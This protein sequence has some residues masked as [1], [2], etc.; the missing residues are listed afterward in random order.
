VQG[1]PPAHQVAETPLA[2]W[3]RQSRDGASG[4]GREESR[5]RRDGSR[6]RSL[7]RRRERSYDPRGA[8]CSTSRSRSASALRDWNTDELL[9]DRL[10]SLSRILV[11]LCRHDGAD[12]GL[13]PSTAGWFPFGNVMAVA[14][15]Q[16][17]AKAKGKTLRP[18]Q[19]RCARMCAPCC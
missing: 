8:S 12:H 6:G 13:V 19:H 4:R 2:G 18:W 7:A 5:S 1:A 16:Q 11:K 15:W 3:G 10:Y 17:A 9:D 14:K